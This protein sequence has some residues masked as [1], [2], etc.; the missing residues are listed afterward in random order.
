MYYDASESDEGGSEWVELCNP[1]DETIDLSDWMLESAGSSFSESWTFPKGTTLAPGAY[2]AFGPGAGDKSEFSPNLQ[3]GGSPTDG[4]RLVQ[5]DGTVI[6]TV[7]YDE[8][9]T[10]KLTDDL[11]SIK[12]PFAPDAPAGSSL[13]RFPDCTETTNDGDDFIVTADLTQG[14]TNPVPPDPIDCSLDPDAVVVINEVMANPAGGD[15]G[16]EW[17]ELYNTGTEIADLSGWGLLGGTTASGSLGAAF[18]DK[19]FLA[20][21]EYL[22]VGGELAAEALGELPD[23]ILSFSLGNAS[24]NADGIMLADCDD[25]IYDTVIYGPELNKNDGWLEDTGKTPTSFAP[26]PGDGEAIARLPN[27]VD[28]DNSGADFATLGYPTPWQAND[29]VG[30]CD[31]QDDIKINEFLPNPDSDTSSSDDTREWV[32]LFNN[33]SVEI[34]LG[35]WELQ[36]GTSSFGDSFLIPAD[37]FIAAGGFLVIGGESVP[38]A[39]VVVP[40]DDDLAMG[41]ASSSPDALRLLHCGPGLSDTVIYGPLGGENSDEWIDDSGEIATSWGPKAV[42]GLSIARRFDGVDSDDSGADFVVSATPSPGEP[43][44]EVSCE[45]DPGTIKINEILPNPSGSDGGNEWMEIVNTGSESVALDDWSIQTGASSWNTKFT[46]PPETIIEPGAYLVIADD[47][48]PAEGVDLYSSTNLSLGNASTGLD[49]VRLLD[50]PGDVAD[51][52]LYGDYDAVA[53]DDEEPWEDDAGGQ[54]FG[55]FPDDENSLGRIPDGADTDDNAVDFQTNLTPTPGRANS[56]SGD[57]GGGGGG[58]GEGGCN[59]KTP[60]ADAP[61]SSKCSSAPL[62]ASPLWALLLVGFIRRRQS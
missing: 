39:D 60:D 3:N 9:N 45:S 7:L 51:T 14:A 40:A 10:N 18:P 22:I 33:S 37:T 29:V 42:A 48:V 44:P 36:W 25:V 20:P 11:G 57:T 38:E 31:G 30:T 54:S 17:I 59:D 26:V 52:L 24:S 46:F 35:G 5:G 4:V 61:G 16:A 13:I 47:E 1:T 58:P 49:G 2:L 34:D 56:A 28:T 19:T 50:C 53:V 62:A 27:G 21:G 6:D 15:S 55:I 8:N 32:E 41:A 43:N 23:V 12:G